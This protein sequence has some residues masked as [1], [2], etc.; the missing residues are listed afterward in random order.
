MTTSA[1]SQLIN[2]RFPAVM[3]LLRLLPKGAYEVLGSAV[4]VGERTVLTA[5]H[6]VGNLDVDAK[7][8]RLFSQNAG[9]LMI[10]S[11]G[12]RHPPFGEFPE[13]RDIQQ[14]LAL[15]QLR[16]RVRGVD[17]IPLRFA[18]LQA[19]AKLTVAG[20][21]GNREGLLERHGFEVAPCAGEDLPGLSCLK[22]DLDSGDSGSPA[23]IGAD[24][25]LEDASVV[26]VFT[27]LLGQTVTELELD[28]KREIHQ[29]WLEDALSEL[30]TKPG[31]R[32]RQLQQVAHL[33]QAGELGV[34]DQTELTFELE[35][36]ADLLIVTVNASPFDD[37]SLNTVDVEVFVNNWPR[38]KRDVA[39]QFRSFRLRPRR[40]VWKAMITALDA[41][42]FQLNWTAYRKT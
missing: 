16:H 20:F 32:R 19:G 9:I 4:L 10:R 23:L 35:Q 8:L 15:I 33:A 14:D 6:L 26:G 27:D 28:R 34:G 12:I 18:A 1:N 17:P 2:G 22:A 31:F 11:G 36:R 3:A 41:A 24:E 5:R 30:E 13:L 7:N 38:G 21:G 40:G 39:S 37:N 42:E 29:R 25:T